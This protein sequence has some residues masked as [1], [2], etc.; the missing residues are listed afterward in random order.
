MSKTAENKKQEKKENEI[1]ILKKGLEKYRIN[2][3][4]FPNSQP[5]TDLNTLCPKCCNIPDISLSKN[6]EEGHYVKCMR[7]RYCYCCSFPFSKTLDDYISLMVKMQQDIIKC[8][9]HKEKGVDIDA[10]YSCE[11][12]QKW[13]CEECINAHINMKEFENHELYLLIK[14]DKISTKN[15]ICP[16]HNLEYIY[17]YLMDFAYG[18]N[19]CK[20]CKIDY[21]DPDSDI[22]IIP[23]EKGE[24]YFNQLKQ[25]IKEGVE[26]L[27]I[28]CKNIYENLINSIKN[29]P[30]LIKKAK[31]IYDKFLIRNRRALFYYQMVIN[32]G[33]PS[34]VNYNMIGNISNSLVT[35]FEKININLKKKLNSEQI[36]Q[37]LNFFDNNYIVGTLE[38]KLD[39]IKNMINIQEIK[40][41]YTIKSEPD[42]KMEIKK[43]TKKEDDKQ[44]EINIIDI[45]ALNVNIIIVGAENGEIYIHEIDN[46]NLKGKLILSQK[47]HDS[48]LV[49]LDKIKDKN[50]K[51]VSCDDTKIKVWGLNKSNDAYIINCEIT[52]NDYSKSNYV[53]LYV[54]NGSNSISFINEENRV[55]I[56]N[57]FYKP[58]FDVHYQTESLKALY[59]I[60]SNDENNSIFIIGGDGNIILYN[61]IGKI[62]CLGSLGIDCFSG[63]SLCYLGNDKLLVGGKDNIYIVNIKNIK[64]EQIIKMHSAECTCFLK[65]N[66]IILCGYGD[67]S[68]CSYWS[69]GIAQ[70][71]LTKFLIVKQNKWNL[72]YHFIEDDFY[73][74][75]ITNSL[76]IDKDK[77][78]SCFYHDDCIKVFQIK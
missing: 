46:K 26:Y 68:I 74:N 61:L 28:Y 11:Y 13:M 44:K 55:K 53:Y 31:E 50:N 21:N 1:L 42:K 56:L 78:I 2:Y 15:I 59:Q 3:L 4:S 52:L 34:F 41:L 17:Y 5:K 38:E 25:I 20:S 58:F 60:E 14:A 39:D 66:D 32:T 45:L 51:F 72:E 65:Y 9:I 48:N 8:E 19:V 54:L 77:F 47:I 10:I 67:T 12:C 71:K 33:T 49:S 30:D 69:N 62:K 22:L 70:T 23:K 7:C 75:G 29:K 76:W 57:T 24:C 27:D 18:F 40:E 64:L 37:I 35:K 36:E 73:Q 16:N 43:K 63:K 6:S